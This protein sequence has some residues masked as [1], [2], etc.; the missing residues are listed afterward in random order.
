MYKIL[1][2]GNNSSVRMVVMKKILKVMLVMVLAITLAGCSC[3]QKSA[4]DRVEE[5]LDQYRNLSA[6]VLGDLDEVVETETDLSEEQKESYRDVLKKQYSDLKYEITNEEYDG[7][8]AVVEA[9]ITVY[10]LYKAQRDA[11]EYLNEHRDEFNDEEGN[12]D[13]SKFMDYRLEQMQKTTD[14]V[15]YTITFNLTKDA[16]DNWQITELSQEDLEKIHG[17]YNYDSE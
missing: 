6:N 15:E 17:I 10:D 2:Y 8:T 5:F 16:D 13:S 12:Y 4:K 11:T 3:M 9:K 7:D 14:T 1:V